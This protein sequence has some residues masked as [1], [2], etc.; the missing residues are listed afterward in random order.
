VI[1]HWF[2]A[3][4]RLR[5]STLSHAKVLM[6]IVFVCA[7]VSACV[8]ADDIFRGDFWVNRSFVG[9]ESGA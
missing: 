8:D 9:I 6:A 7:F 2:A 1:A 4:R 3:C 5:L